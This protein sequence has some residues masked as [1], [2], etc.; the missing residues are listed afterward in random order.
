[1]CLILC[2]VYAAVQCPFLNNLPNYEVTLTKNMSVFSVAMYS[3]NFNYLIVGAT[4][5]AC[6]IE[7]TWSGSE[8]LC[9]GKISQT[10]AEKSLSLEE[11]EREEEREGE[12]EG[13]R[14]RDK[15]K[16]V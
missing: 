13:E 15:E 16:L 12:G 10:A 11:R 8:P 9:F 7:G 2:L 6:Q 4:N 14:K 1:M 3:C 5:W